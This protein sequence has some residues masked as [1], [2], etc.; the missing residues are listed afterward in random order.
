MDLR[1]LETFVVVINLKSFS[2]AAKKLFLTQPT[3]TNHIQNLENELG[4]IL[5][6]RHGKNISPTSAGNILYD[7]ALNIINMRDMA[8]FKLN[9]YKGK[10]EGTLE[11][12]SSSIPKQYILPKILTQFSSK[13]PEVKFSISKNDSKNVIESILDGFS[14]FGLVGAKYNSNNLEYI[15]LIDDNL[16]IVTPNNENFPYECGVELDYEFLIKQKIIMREEGS[17]TRLGFEDYLSRSNYNLENLNIIA[18]IED[19]ET[20]KRFIE[21][22]FGISILSKLAIK[23]EIESG[24]M[25]YYNIKSFDDTRSFYFVYHKKRHLS[26]L[27]Q[28]FKDFIL[29]YIKEQK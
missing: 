3:I 24:L 9:E 8:A 1:Q 21:L 2:K 28:T 13:Y 20:I 6:N 11:I 29:H 16:V 19:N 17:G 10:F 5:I 4:T 12:S 7:Y 18:H 23:K 22:G 27:A 25:K 14:D 15:K 26:P